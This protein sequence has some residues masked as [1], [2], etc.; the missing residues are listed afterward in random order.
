M[1]Y[2]EEKIID[3]DQFPSDNQ[4]AFIIYFLMAISEDHTLINFNYEIEFLEK[5]NEYFSQP[6]KDKKYEY[7]SYL[8]SIICGKIMLFFIDDYKEL[9]NYVEEKD[10][11]ILNEYYDKYKNN[12][13]ENLDIFNKDFG[14]QNTFVTLIDIDFE[15]LYANII[16]YLI[17]NKKFDDFEYIENIFEQLNIENIYITNKMFQMIS[18][19]LNLDNGYLIADAKDIIKPNKVNFYYL[20]IKYV[21]K[22]SFYIYQIPFLIQTRKAILTFVKSKS[23]SYKK[24]KKT[25]KERSEYVINYFLD[26]QYYIQ[27]YSSNEDTPKLKMLLEF[28]RD[29]YPEEKKEQIN[30]L[31]GLIQKNEKFPPKYKEDYEKAANVNERKKI[32][33]FFSD[34]LKL[35]SSK[36]ITKI[37]VLKKW[38]TIEQMLKDKKT[39]KMKKHDKEILSNFLDEEG[40]KEYF[41]KLFS[42]DTFNY[43][44]S[45]NKK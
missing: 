42:E 20:M 25:I 29:Y 17:K 44:K 32:L 4:F 10:D 5:M 1:L 41:I 43:F 3:V 9:D 18:E 28:F 35:K 12:I 45:A 24:A 22:D 23:I 38:E 19:A 30:E 11:K 31:E 39:S 14:T 36:D 2:N 7:K 21:L 15:E 33:Q 16:T 6:K 8:Y 13:N 26:S 37:E 34:K 40:N 27:L